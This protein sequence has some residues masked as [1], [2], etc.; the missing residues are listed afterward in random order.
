M[1][2]ELKNQQSMQE[3]INNLL[4]GKPIDPV[5]EESAEEAIQDVVRELERAERELNA[6]QSRVDRLK[7][8]L[9]RIT[10]K[11]QDKA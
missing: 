1:V 2:L 4:R 6:A 9:G 5:H 10:G 3:R 8:E 11:T 7:N